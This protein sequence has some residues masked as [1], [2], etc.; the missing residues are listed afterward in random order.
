LS[1]PIRTDLSAGG[2]STKG[3][4]YIASTHDGQFM[5]FLQIFMG[6]ALLA[7]L[8]GNPESH[9]LYKLDAGLV[10]M[11]GNGVIE[12]PPFVYVQLTILEF[13]STHS[14]FNRECHPFVIIMF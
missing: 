9:I 8:E 12:F 5:W 2:L 11:R 1:K 10:K 6:C 4:E 7:S 13:L 14:R 3:R